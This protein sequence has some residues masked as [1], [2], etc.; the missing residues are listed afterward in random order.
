MKNDNTRLSQNRQKKEEIVANVAEKVNK[1]K[2]IVFTNYAGLTHVQLEGIK[3][4]AGKMDAEYVATKNSLLQLA[5]KERNLSPEDAKK[6]Q[7]PTATL[8]IYSDI[9]LPLKALTKTM[10]ELSLPTIKFGLFEGKSLNSAEV[11]KLS[12]LP[13]LPVLRAQ[14]LGQLLSPIQGLHRSLNWNMQKF[15]MTLNAIKDRKTS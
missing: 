13:P 14:F 3:K 2:A 12:T 9:L 11:L 1:A 15:V 10:K 7:Q 8:F 5:L 4:T 6:L